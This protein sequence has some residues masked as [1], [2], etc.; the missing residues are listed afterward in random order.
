MALRMSCVQV[1][2]VVCPSQVQRHDVVA[3]ECG[4]E[5]ASAKVALPLLTRRDDPLDVGVELAAWHDASC[6]G[7]AMEKM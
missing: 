1:V 2:D 5:G 4:I 6:A 3:L 7:D